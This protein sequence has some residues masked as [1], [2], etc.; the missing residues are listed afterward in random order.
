MPF[1]CCLQKT[2]NNSKPEKFIIKHRCRSCPFST[3]I[4][5]LTQV[6]DYFLLHFNFSFLLS[7]FAPIFSSSL[8]KILTSCSFYLFALETL[9]LSQKKWLIFKELVFF[10]FLILDQSTSIFD[11]FFLITRYTR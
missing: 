3:I 1:V 4:T 2:R 10:L 5:L 9:H 8:K 6:L 11:D 7:F